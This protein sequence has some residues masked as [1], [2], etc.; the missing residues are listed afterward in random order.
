MPTAFDSQTADAV[1]LAALFVGVLIAFTGFAQLFRRRETLVE[2]RN[3]RMRMIRAGIETEA[4]LALLRPRDETGPWRHI[5]LLRQLPR[6]LR[7]AGMTVT[8]G[9]FVLFSAL[10]TGAILLAALALLPLWK[11][12]GIG[13]VLGVGAPALL[14]A[15]RQ[16]E[17]MRALTAQLPDALELMARGLR[18]GHPLNTSIK[19]VAEQMPDPIGSEFGLIFDQ[20]NFGDDLPNAVRDFATRTDLEDVHYLTASIAIQ[21]GT[22]GDLARI[23]SMLSKIIRGRISM[24]RKIK[25]ISAEGRMTAWILSA[26]PFVIVGYNLFLNDGYYGAIADDPAFKKML[27][28]AFLLTLANFLVLRRLV[29][30]QI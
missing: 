18:V 27:A 13:L 10:A 11:A 7:R 25:A 3:R 29:S 30:F 6:A 19:S 9:R 28:A 5:P 21:H 16:A 23:L 8:P 2:A 17:R 15:Y 14:L 20:I 22:G 24:R 4:I 12:V 1:F 26:V